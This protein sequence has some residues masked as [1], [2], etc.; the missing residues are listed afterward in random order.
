MWVVFINTVGSSGHNINRWCSETFEINS[1]LTRMTEKTTAFRWPQNFE[2]CDSYL[3]HVAIDLVYAHDIQFI[4]AVNVPFRNNA[5][6]CYPT[7]SYRPLVTNVQE[8]ARSTQLNNKYMDQSRLNRRGRQGNGSF[9]SRD[10]A[11]GIKTGYGLHEWGIGLESRY[12]QSISFLY[13][14][15]TGSGTHPATY[16]IVPGAL[17]SGVKRT[18]CEADHPT[19]ISVVDIYTHSQIRLNGAVLN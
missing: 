1:T 7:A 16:P 18:G 11:V 13:I 9:T 8:K 14:V 19:P 17:S 2:S 12:K 15:Q 10:S 3:K 4:R 5:I 6:L